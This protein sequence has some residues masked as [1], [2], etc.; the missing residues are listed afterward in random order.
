MS[1]LTT[2][3]ACSQMSAWRLVVYRLIGL[4]FDV[5][6]HGA[7]VLVSNVLLLYLMSLNIR[8]PFDLWTTLCSLTVSLVACLF[9]YGLLS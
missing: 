8:D 3:Y 7:D 9:F 5:L 4:H 2:A 6:P 1:H